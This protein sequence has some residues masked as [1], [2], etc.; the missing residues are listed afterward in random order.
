MKNL[1]QVHHSFLHQNNSPANRIS[2][3]VSCVCFCAGIQLCSIACKKLVPEKTCTRLTDTRARFLSVCCRH[4]SQSQYI[5]SYVL[6]V[7]VT[8]SDL[9]NAVIN[10]CFM[11][12]FKD[13]IRLLAC[14][15]DAI[16]NLLGTTC[17]LSSV[18]FV[19]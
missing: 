19:H 9:T 1:T 13:L 6:T 7:K 2:R 14:Y 15:N 18:S 5:L 3:F 12:L 10:A 8:K 4:H 11:M 17:S 16:I